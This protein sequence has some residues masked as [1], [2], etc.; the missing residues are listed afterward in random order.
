MASLLVPV[1]AAPGGHLRAVVAAGVLRTQLRG[2]AT[3]GGDAGEVTTAAHTAPGIGVGFE[4]P[5]P[6]AGRRLRI[7]VR[8]NQLISE[9]RGGGSMAAGVGFRL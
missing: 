1:I 2:F 8:A 4:L 7:V 6:L 3:T 5:M 9:E